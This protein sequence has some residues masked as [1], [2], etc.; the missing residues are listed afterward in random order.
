MMTMPPPA[1]LKGPLSS[2][3][4]VYS[5]LEGSLLTSGRERERGLPLSIRSSFA[6]AMGAAKAIVGQHGVSS[7]M[8]PLRASIPTPAI[9]SRAFPFGTEFVLGSAVLD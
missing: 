4:A 9:T 2:K 7:R 3:R 5:Q 8:A 6:N 1:Q